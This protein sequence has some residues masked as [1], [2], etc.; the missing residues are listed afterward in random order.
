MRHLVFVTKSSILDKGNYFG[1]TWDSRKCLSDNLIMTSNE[2][3]NYMHDL[4]LGDNEKNLHS[5]SNFV[6]EVFKVTN[7]QV[8]EDKGIKAKCTHVQKVVIVCL[9]H[10]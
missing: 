5:P 2:K 8:C 7:T 9:G 4:S 1:G 3:S 6:L 10:H